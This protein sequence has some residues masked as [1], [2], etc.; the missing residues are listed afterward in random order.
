DVWRPEKAHQY[1]EVWAMETFGAALSG[2][3][4]DIQ[5]RHYLL[6]SSARPDHIDWTSFN[7][8]EMEQRLNDYAEL[9]AK[10]K[11]LEPQIPERLKSA[12]FHLIAY[13]VQGAAAMNEKI[14]GGKLSFDRAS[15]GKTAEA[16][17]LADRAKE[18]YRSIR[19]LTNTYNKVLADG[20]WDGMMSYSPGSRGF[21]YEPSV[22]TPDIVPDDSIPQEIPEPT[23]VIAAKD[24]QNKSANVKI[25]EEL[26][27]AGSSVAVLPLDMTQYTSSNIASAPSVSYSLRLYPG[28][29]RLSLKFLPTFPL[30]PGLDLRYAVSVDNGAPQI[31]SLKTEEKALDWKSNILRGYAKREMNIES[32]TEK[33]AVVKIYFADPGVVLSA[34]EVTSVS[35]DT[36]TN[37]IVNP[38]F[39]INSSGTQ[40]T[41]TTRG[42][43][44]GWSRNVAISGNSYGTNQD[45][46][47]YHGQNVCWFVSTPM[48][49]DFRLQQTVSGLP[50]GEY[51][52]RCMLAVP[53]ARMTNQ[54]IFANKYVQYYGRE[55]DYASNLTAGEINS[56]A[57]YEPEHESSSGEMITLKEMAVRFLVSDGESVRLGIASGNRKGDG[58]SA[59]DNSGFFKVDH[60]RLECI[61]E[62]N[63]DG[64]KTMLGD[65]IAEAQEL[66]ASTTGG[67]NGGEYPQ[68]ARSAFQTSIQSARNM[69]QNTGATGTQ[70]SNAYENLKKA[71]HTYKK[72][73]ITY[74]SY[75]VNGSF[76]Y[77]SAGVLNDGTTVRGT[78]YGWYDTGISGNSYGIN[79][80]ANN[81]DGNNVC[82]YQWSPMPDNFELYQNVTGL[83]A[84]K[85]KLRCKM[86][87]SNGGI[88]T[89]R[90]FANGN[91]R[92]YGYSTDYGANIA[93]GEKY[94]FACFGTSNDH[95]LQEM[96][97]DVELAEGETLQL[98][99][100]SSNKKKDGSASTGNAGLFKV[101]HFRLELKEA[102]GNVNSIRALK[103]EP[104]FFARGE[105]RSC[106]IG[107]ERNFNQAHVMIYS[108][109]GKVVYSCV[110]KEQ[111]TR[112]NLPQGLYIVRIIA[113]GQEQSLK[114][115]V[116]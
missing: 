33:N 84:G 28:K 42:V 71:I 66:Y 38:D 25:I 40:L 44:Y 67:A 98:G 18:A 93:S 16:F 4:A 114:V 104:L 19:D 23:T 106:L 39:E 96:E 12:Y 89:Q 83:P 1:A 7:Y 115:P 30:Y 77:K 51:L 69:Y 108:L 20:K 91:V 107:F 103:K 85:Y 34:I 48:S 22:V 90:L 63:G 36:L 100:R 92:Y 64:L 62:F 32:E 105:K 112:V 47:N 13:P 10:V 81:K 86:S 49:A 26:G 46:V 5:R 72:S 35:A 101:D 41:G 95:N 24:Y 37:T 55:S 15:R 43:P 94:G 109:S 57:G 53:R 111:E 79:S 97:I 6:A 52:L 50:A 73:M 21:F 61:R 58:T 99:V 88:T 87:V 78:P 29:N 9:V 54:R 59:T 110:V 11:E 80:D 27:V 70:L 2:A 82:W 56:F 75:I 116:S 45:A 3:I 68:T 17:A 31:V 60:F 76:E 8:R 65:L 113:D 14:L 102:Y 74:G